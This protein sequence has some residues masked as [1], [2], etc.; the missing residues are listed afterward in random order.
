MKYAS[1]I[2]LSNFQTWFL[3]YERSARL[4]LTNVIVDTFDLTLF[5]EETTSKLNK[6]LT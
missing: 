4:N 2:E 5:S 6:L 1:N 3:A